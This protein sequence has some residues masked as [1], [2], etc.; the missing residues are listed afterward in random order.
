[1]AVIL[2]PPQVA[3]LR[4]PAGVT[5]PGVQARTQ[6]LLESIASVGL[7][8]R[9]AHLAELASMGPDVIPVILERPADAIVAMALREVIGGL[10]ER[11]TAREHASA[12]LLQALRRD[13]DRSTRLLALTFLGS[14][15]VCNGIGFIDKA[16]EI[17]LDPDEPPELRAQALRTLQAARLNAS[18][19]VDLGKLLNISTLGPGC[20]SPLRDA[21]FACIGKHAELLV[22]PKTMTQLDDFL[23]YPDP[24]IR[25]HA[26]NLVGKIGDTDAIERLSMLP[27][28]QEDLEPI[29]AAIRCIL[30]RP[31]NILKLR[32]EHFE[33]FVGHL[34]RRMG[35]DVEVT[36]PTK[37]EGIDVISFKQ[38]YTFK[39]PARERWVVQCKRW[40][41]NKVDIADLEALINRSREKD[42]KH[43]LLITTSSFTQRALAYAEQ[44]QAAI[45][46][47]S[48]TQLLEAVDQLLGPGR[49]TIRIR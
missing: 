45:E 1:L 47:V 18:H 42:A 38:G 29:Q 23:I 32:W 37:D 46:L 28:K 4:Y 40:T 13:R 2:R 36:R 26:I 44:H 11:G 3:S 33:H 6:S 24:V 34:L 17:A 41:E 7:L 10:G 5:D 27:N 30:E 25:S 31:T 22:V 19:V 9:H 49:Y 16:I 48:G 35:H 12:H 43:A 39:G 8:D 20:P 15:P 14:P 21:M